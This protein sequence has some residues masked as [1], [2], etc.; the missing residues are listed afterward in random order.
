MEINK[1]HLFIEISEEHFIFFVVIYDQ[2]LNFEIIETYKIKSEGISNGQISDIESSSKIIKNSLKIIEKKIKFTFKTVTIINDE[3][4][5]KC[6]NVS[7]FK[8]LSGSQITNENISYILNN[9]K[10]LV[11]SSNSKYALIHLFN[12]RFILDKADLNKLPIGLYGE[13]YNH[14]LTFFLLSKNNIKNLKLT[15]NK[16]HL[17]IDRIILKSFASGINILK[18]YINE[19]KFLL[20]NIGYENSQIS[21]FDN[22]SFIFLEK[23]KFGSNIIMRDIS[24]L[25]SLKLETVKD[26][27]S[28]IDF[29]DQKNN[30]YLPKKYFQNTIFRKI[31]I[32]HLNKIVSARVE[33]IL[34]LILKKNINLKNM[35]IRDQKK[36]I[37]FE[38]M[39]QFNNLYQ[40]FK[41]NFSDVDNLEFLKKTSDDYL[42]SCKASA[43]LIGK[44]W[45]KEA[46]PVIQTKKSVLSRIFTSIFD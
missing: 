4:N 3:E 21:F 19:K 33:E 35:L 30:K 25:C 20:I 14:N 12:S 42:N 11:T 16:C 23:F 28:E 22:S 26:I 41:N 34:N 2:T 17:E 36:F 9:M 10:K 45:E 5:F 31:S 38:D 37:V 32:S 40:Q 29:T 39:Q 18:K 27:F 24:K 8:K 1:P 6:I 13:F 15:L 7:G 46:I 44:G 43:D